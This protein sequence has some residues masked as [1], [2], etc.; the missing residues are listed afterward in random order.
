MNGGKLSVLA[1]LVSSWGGGKKSQRG[2]GS[3]PLGPGRE[4]ETKWGRGKDL[5]G[6]L[7]IPQDLDLRFCRGGGLK[8]AS[9]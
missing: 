7:G 6:N 4:K 1:I 9:S 3:S 2:I 5:L 8:G